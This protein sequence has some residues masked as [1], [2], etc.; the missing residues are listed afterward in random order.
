LRGTDAIRNN[1]SREKKR[2]FEILA[3]NTKGGDWVFSLTGRAR[4]QFKKATI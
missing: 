3:C 4:T 1:A 2:F